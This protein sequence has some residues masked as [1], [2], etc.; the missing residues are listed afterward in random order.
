MRWLILTHGPIE[1]NHYAFRWLAKTAKGDGLVQWNLQSEDLVGIQML[2]VRFWSFDTKE[3]ELFLQQT[4]NTTN[5]EVY[6]G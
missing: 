6:V 3:N 1:E 5:G 4:R 2:Q